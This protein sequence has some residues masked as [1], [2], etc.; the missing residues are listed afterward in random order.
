MHIRDPIHGS[1]EIDANERA[2]IDSRHFQRLRSIKQLGFADLAFP[3]ATHSR[4]SHGIGAMAVASRLFDAI[5]K[6][7]PLPEPDRA[8]LRQTLRLAVLLHDLG[9]PPLSHTSE[10][11]LPPRETLGLP[12]WVGDSHVLVDSQG[13]HHEA[14]Q[15]SHEDMTLLLLL[16]SS[17]ADVIRTRFADLGIAP[18]HVAA[19]VCG[20][21]P[22][23]G[24]PFVVAGF[25]HAPLLRQVV[26]SELDADRMDYLLRDSF[27]TGVHYGRYDLDWL[28]QNLVPVPHEGALHLGIGHRA[29]FAFEDFLLSRYHMFLSVYYH[30]TS[31]N[32][33]QLLARYYRTSGDEFT[34]SGDPEAYVLADDVALMS[35]LRRSD[36]PWAKRIV[37]R[38]GFALAVENNPFER[39]ADLSGLMHALDEAGIQHFETESRGVLS[40]YFGA[41]DQDPIFVRTSTGD[42]AAIEKYTPVYKRYAESARLIRV[43]VDPD[44]V[45]EARALAGPLARPE[46]R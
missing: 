9:H 13:Q 5:Y 25:D 46:S 44:R 28:A 15:A 37:E 24:S 16:K 31:I 1:I 7:T 8:R 45:K 22:P 26:S 35:A 41:T 36:N 23:G 32:Y 2:V 29:V 14:G 33:E 11:I 39:P 12:E 20:K 6:N 34:L 3:G 43:Y 40:K 27:F 42:W 19:L 10:K 38:R 4:Y 21:P 18:E 17:L 30:Y